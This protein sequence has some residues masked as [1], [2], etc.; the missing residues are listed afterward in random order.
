MLLLLVQRCILCCD[1]PLFFEATRKQCSWPT[2]MS[3]A[4]L[5]DAQWTLSLMSMQ[6]ELLRTQSALWLLERV[7]LLWT[8]VLLQLTSVLAADV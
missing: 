8:H 3:T 5:R 2:P 6:L 1:G 4:P 7:S